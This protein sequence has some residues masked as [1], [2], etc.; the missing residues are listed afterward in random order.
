[1]AT[2]LGQLIQVG[3]LALAGLM[4]TQALESVVEVNTRLEER[5]QEAGVLGQQV[6]SPPG[7]VVCTGDTEG[8]GGG[9]QG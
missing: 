5:E 8:T 6:S 7:Q 4:E 1:M 2:R 9:H 3:S